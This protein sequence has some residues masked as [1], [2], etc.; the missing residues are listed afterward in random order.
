V[1]GAFPQGLSYAPAATGPSAAATGWRA[2]F[3]DAKLKAIIEQALAQNRDLRTAV[4]NIQ[5]ARAQYMTQRSALFPAVT[6]SG[7]EAY[8]H[9][10]FEPG[11]SITERYYSADLGFSSWEIDLFGRTRSLSRA[12]REQLYASRDARVAFQ[13]TLIAEVATDYYTLAADRQLLDVAQRTVVS[14]K[15]SLDLTVSRMNAGQASELDVRQA[16]TTLDQARSDVA[17]YTTNAAQALNALNLV[18]GAAVS[19]ALLPKALPPIEGQTA[20][21][22]AGTSSEVLLSRPDVLEAEHQLRAANADIGAA[23][24]AFF[25]EITLTG[26]VGQESTA[27]SSLFNPAS[28]TWLFQPGATLPIFEGGKNVAGLKS[29]KAS[30]DAAI[31]AYEKAIQTAFSEVANALARQGTIGDQLAAQQALVEASNDSYRLSNARYERG[32]D[33]Y[34]NVLVA[35]RALYSAQQTQISTALAALANAVELYRALGGGQ[36]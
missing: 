12:A 10:P 31:A 33:T 23:R 17:Q 3:T 14:Q 11:V 9:I 4:A 20:P 18:V 1:P 19:E 27:L 26:Q 30:R 32:A 16:E 5:T 6:A 21:L 8:E 7:G 28:R 29:A 15:A 2:F 36:S 22:A 25:P 34:L 13:T 35:E 24:A